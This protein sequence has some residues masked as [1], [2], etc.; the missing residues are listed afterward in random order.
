MY[1]LFQVI[2][3]FSSDWLFFI[4]SVYWNSH[5]VHPLLS[6][7]TIFM[8]IVLN[9]LSGILLISTSFSYNFC[10]VLSFGTCSSA[11]SFFLSVLVSVYYVGQLCLLVLKV[12]TLHRRGPVAQCLLV[13]RTR[14]SKGVP[15]GLN[16]PSSCD[17]AVI[18]FGPAGCKDLCCL[19]WAQW[20][21]FPPCIIKD[22]LCGPLGLIGEQGRY[23]P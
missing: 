18:A 7:V 13:I 4:F 1:L 12:V 14:H 19:L 9:S 20:A 16:A 5:W 3:F 2:E 23:S 6:P 8:T 17:W 15:C 21:G 10:L 11:S 22:L